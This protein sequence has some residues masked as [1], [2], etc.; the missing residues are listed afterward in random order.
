MAG[1]GGPITDPISSSSISLDSGTT[2]DVIVTGEDRDLGFGTYVLPFTT[3]VTPGVIESVTIAPATVS[4]WGD[5]S[6]TTDEP[7]NTALLV[8]VL[9]DNAGS[10]DPIPDDDLAGNSTG[11][12]VGDTPV[13]LSGLLVGTYPAI[14]LRAGLNTTDTSVTP[15]LLDWQVTYKP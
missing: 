6:F 11:F 9:Y 7:A 14:R 2:W 4:E 12:A 3:F 15:K 13:D 5:L 1:D 8:Q 10:W